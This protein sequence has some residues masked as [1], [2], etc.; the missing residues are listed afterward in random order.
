[1]PET[2]RASRH[3]QLQT[4]RPRQRLNRRKES[5]GGKPR[6]GTDLKTE[7]FRKLLHHAVDLLSLP[8]QTETAQVVTDGV[9]EAH[10]LE[11]HHIH[12]LVQHLLSTSRPRKPRYMFSSPQTDLHTTG[13]AFCAHLRRSSRSAASRNRHCGPR[14]AP[15]SVTPYLVNQHTKTYAQQI[16]PPHTRVEESMVELSRTE[17]IRVAS[18]IRLE[19][20]S[21]T[22]PLEHPAILISIE[23]KSSIA[24]QSAREARRDAMVFCQ[25]TL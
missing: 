2:P 3:M 20:P 5:R 22:E 23:A 19:R 13:G 15:T 10:A 14:L 12:I 17:S 11:V 1:M 25:Q 21:R 7:S 16:R 24:S 6:N 18:S 4:P 8:R 9:V